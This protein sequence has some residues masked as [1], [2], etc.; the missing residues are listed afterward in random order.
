MGERCN[1]CHGVNGNSTDPRF[2]C[3]PASASNICRRSLLDYHAGRARAAR[4]LPCPAGL[5]DDDVESNIASL[6]CHQKARAV[7]FV[8]AAGQVTAPDQPMDTSMSKRHCTG[9]TCIIRSCPTASVCFTRRRCWSSAW[10]ICSPCSTS[11]SPMPAVRAAI[12]MMLSYHGHPDRGLF[13]QRQGL[14]A[15]IR[16]ARADVDH[17]AAATSAT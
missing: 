16:A 17:A 13:G 3:S 5:S 6:L 7:L 10:A 11:T 2:R 8:T 9:T 4:W 14:A 15:G 1:R 12:R